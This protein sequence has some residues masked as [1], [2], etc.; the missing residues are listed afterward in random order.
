M[1][2]V[3][4]FGS[5]EARIGRGG[6]F[7]LDVP[8]HL[9]HFTPATLQS[10]LS[11]AGLET[12]E[13]THVAPEYDIF[14][15]VQTAE[16][17][18]GLPPNLLY[19][20][21]RK[22]EARLAHRSFGSVLPVAAVAGAAVLGVIGLAWMPIA[23]ALGQSSTITVY[24]RRPGERRM[25]E[26]IPPPEMTAATGDRRRRIW[27]QGSS[28]SL[29]AMGSPR[30]ALAA[31]GGGARGDRAPRTGGARLG[32]SRPGTGPSRGPG[33]AGWS[34]RRRDARGEGHLRHSRSTDRVR[35]AH[36]RRAPAT[37]RCR[38][39]RRIA[40][41]RGGG[42]RQDRDHRVR[43][44]EPG[45]TTNPHR[46]THT[47]GGSSS[48]SAAAVAAGMVDLALGTQTAGSVIR[49]ASFCGVLG[50]K[51]TFNL[52]PT[53]GMKQGAQSLDTVGVFA[54]DFDVLEAAYASLVGSVLPR[55]GEA[56]GFVLVRTDQWDGADSDCKD[57]IER[58]AAAVGAEPRELAEPFVGLADA[59]RCSCRRTSAPDRSPGSVSHHLG[60]PSRSSLREML[61]LGDGIE[62]R[63]V[64][65]RPRSG[66]RTREFR[67]CSRGAVRAR[68][69]DRD[70]R[71]GRRSSRRALLDGIAPRPS[72]A[73][74]LCSAF[75]VSPCPGSSD[76]RDCRSACSWS[77]G[78]TGRRSFSGPGAPSLPSRSAE[79][80]KPRADGRHAGATGDWPSPAEPVRPRAGR[81][82]LTRDRRREQQSAARV[83][84]DDRA[85]AAEHGQPEEALSRS[86]A[87]P[88]RPRGP[89]RGRTSWAATGRGKSGPLGPQIPWTGTRRSG[90][91]SRSARRRCEHPG[92]IADERI[93]ADPVDADRHSPA[94]AGL[95]RHVCPPTPKATFL[96][97]GVSPRSLARPRATRVSDVPESSANR[98][99]PSPPPNIFFSIKWRSR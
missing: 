57:V 42:D 93:R 3:P 78:P 27:P 67:R 56:P 18:L 62:A 53:A 79:P 36:L 19:D 17:R 70:C 83:V 47:P 14:S 89:R 1:V 97:V 26:V 91:R 44:L 58:A 23:A 72:T 8:R 76:R 28:V 2:G 38:R 39:R 66:P 73:S 15:F 90:C 95:D 60:P 51:P 75:P 34:A 86:P 22:R 25:C 33:G 31:A 32:L 24:A 29:S 74:G 96:P 84:D 5:P 13:T 21:L 71:R 41:R 64:R 20:V 55:S 54:K 10:L 46:I 63:R 50:L 52:L 65:L 85:V 16:N 48:G 35:L 68:R 45:P 87:H 37:C 88:S 43:H 92:R 6:W 82:S 69:R 7:H 30:S 99:G 80:A 40:R 61:E 4:N 9:F 12:V 77:P 94:T 49:P 98:N 59:L 81:S 11:D